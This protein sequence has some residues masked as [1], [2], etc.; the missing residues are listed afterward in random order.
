MPFR[1]LAPLIPILGCVSLIISAL[2]VAQKKRLSN[3][4]ILSLVL[5]QDP[6]FSHM[7]SVFWGDTFSCTAPTLFYLGLGS[8]DKVLGSSDFLCAFSAHCVCV[9]RLYALGAPSTAS[10]GPLSSAIS[11]VVVFCLSRLVIL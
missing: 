7:L 5:F 9:L 3:D 4:E 10:R 6:S 8:G 11:V 2:L 1:V